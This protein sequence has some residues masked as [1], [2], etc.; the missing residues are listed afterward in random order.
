MTSAVEDTSGD[1]GRGIILRVNTQIW[2]IL[3]L[4]LCA[5]GCGG[6]DPSAVDE[7][8]A[9]DMEIAEPSDPEAIRPFAI[10]IPEDVLTD[11]RLRLSQRRLPDQIPGTGWEYGTER[12]YLEALLSYWEH[13]FDWRAQETM[14]NQFDQF[15]SSID[16]LDIHF[17]HQR[18]PN[19]DA[20][21][22]LV[23]HGWPG[24]FAEFSK[25][26]GPLTD[27]AAHGGDPADAF[28]VVAASLPGF[29]FS[30]KP[31]ERG[32]NP[33]RMS[34]ILAKL[35]ERLGYTEY[36]AQGGDWGGIISRSHAFNYPDRVIGLHLNFVLAGPPADVDDPAAG[37]PP[38]QLE[39]MRERQAFMAN[40]TGYQGI[41]GTKPQ[42]LGY[43][44]ND[45]PA[46]LAGWI[47]EKFHGWSDID[48]DLE[49]KF[50]KN[51]LLTDI[52]IYW[53]T[54]TITSSTRI[55]YESR[56]V[57]SANPIGY[58]EVPT[59]GLIFPAEII[60]PPQ[61]WAEA[62]YNLVRWT[63]MPEG[64]HF[65]ALEEPDALIGDVRA[66]FRDYR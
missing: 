15:K 36:G 9:A 3:A 59:A 39:R 20:L 54:Q 10:D 58:I 40:E 1:I 65:A 46:G 44:L 41:Q 6:A 63:E 34:D 52:M 23:T 28:H 16:G 18:S 50:T 2:S 37:V 8:V 60:I 61:Q 38:E 30:D 62:A 29:G 53:V 32:F 64:G 55:Y 66:F 13:D 35:M 14:L 21:P 7:P 5:V 57:R 33:E 19:D 45:S 11:L 25:I 26:I 27:P 24:S 42:T 12:G 22:L 51:E 49:S 31:T 56:N 47:V 4:L 48:G 43:G 17:I